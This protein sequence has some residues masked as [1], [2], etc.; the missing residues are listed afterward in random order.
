MGGDNTLGVMDN[1]LPPLLGSNADD[2][3]IPPHIPGQD[4]WSLTSGHQ[5]DY[6][7]PPIQVPYVGNKRYRKRG[8]WQSKIIF[9]ITSCH[10]RKCTLQPRGVRKVT[11]NTNGTP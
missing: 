10:R 7:P 1:K 9:C 11:T 4:N 5:G 3:D 8:M 2:A 6:P